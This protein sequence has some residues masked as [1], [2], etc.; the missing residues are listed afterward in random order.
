MNARHPNQNLPD[1]T[2]L[3]ATYILMAVT[4][5]L[6]G[7]EKDELSQRREVI[8]AST[9]YCRAGMEWACTRDEGDESY[10]E[11][12]I[13]GQHFCVSGPSGGHYVGNSV[14]TSYSTTG[15]TLNPEIDEPNGSFFG[16]SFI[17]PFM[18]GQTEVTEEFS[19]RVIIRTPWIRGAEIHPPTRYLDEFVKEGEY[20]LPTRWDRPG[21]DFYFHIS[22]S[23][24]HR[25]GIGYYQRNSPTRI[26][27]L[28]VLLTTAGGPPG[29]HTFRIAEVTKWEDPFAATY[30]ITFEVSCDLYYFGGGSVEYYG[31]LEDGLFRT[32][33]TIQK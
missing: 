23:C 13:N 9:E 32:V 3:T 8:V 11:G 26:P 19:P 1:M 2:R 6:G 22:W 33:F 25:P 21:D 10:F 29:L 20:P 16:F 5:L 27:T 15:P 12:W 17:P 14:G 30:R 18:D 24:V 31:R 28:S 4:L 7:C